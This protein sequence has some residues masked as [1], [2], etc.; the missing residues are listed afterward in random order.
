MY[1]TNIVTSNTHVCS[2][3]KNG[4]KSNSGKAKNKTKT[5][6]GLFQTNIESF[7]DDQAGC[8]DGSEDEDDYFDDDYEDDSFID[9][10]DEVDNK[11]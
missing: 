6:N 2:V 11:L 8:S 10:T 3:K 9:N 1:A 7:F 5:R 4:K